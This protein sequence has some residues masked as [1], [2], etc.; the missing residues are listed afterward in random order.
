MKE[1]LTPG[2]SLYTINM[3]VAN[4]AAERMVMGQKVEA[5]LLKVSANNLGHWIRGDVKI[6]GVASALDYRKP[7]DGDADIRV[8]A[9][10]DEN[11]RTL[12]LVKVQ[13]GEDADDL[14]A[15][16]MGEIVE[17]R[18]EFIQANALAASVDV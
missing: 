16:L 7:R 10:L 9:T 5:A 14:F 17:P 6:N 8:Q 13:H 3:D 4:F 11:A 15:K 18:R 12:L 2:S 1:D